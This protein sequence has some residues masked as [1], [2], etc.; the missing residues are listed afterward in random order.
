[1]LGLVEGNTVLDLDDMNVEIFNQCCL[2]DSNIKTPPKVGNQAM[3]DGIVGI[4]TKKII[5]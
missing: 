5:S 1:M 3:I 2:L 4:G